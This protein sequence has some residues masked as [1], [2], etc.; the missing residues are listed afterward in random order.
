M[1]HS[2]YDYLPKANV[3]DLRTNGVFIAKER[4]KTTAY[5]LDSL[6]TGGQLFVNPG[7]EVYEG[8]I[9]GQNS[10]ENDLVVN[11][12][13]LKKL[14]NMRSKAADDAPMLT[15]PRIMNLEQ[16]VEYIAPD[17]LVEITPESIRL[18]KKILDHLQRKRSSK[19]ESEE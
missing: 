19:N 15:P 9:V 17:E 8:M 6:Q 14:S 10:R 13:K 1:H 16:A 5:A 12:C 4:G 18:R 3:A 7:T 11:P 2:F